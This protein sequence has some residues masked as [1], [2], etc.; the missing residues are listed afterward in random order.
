[1]EQKDQKGRSIDCT[2]VDKDISMHSP[3][4]PSQEKPA[5][6]R[7]VPKLFHSPK[8]LAKMGL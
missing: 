7:G 5:N 6:L 4:G 2:C 1:M 3:T 8:V